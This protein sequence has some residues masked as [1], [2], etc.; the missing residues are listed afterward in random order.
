VKF[1]EVLDALEFVSV[2]G[3]LNYQAYICLTTGTVHFL[4]DAFDPEEEELPD[5]FNESDDYVAVPTKRDLD[6]GN[7]LV[8]LLPRR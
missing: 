2:G 8:F 6:L 1:S 3:L 4:S 7:R 5:G